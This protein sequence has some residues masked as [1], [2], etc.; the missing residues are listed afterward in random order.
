LSAHRD[1]PYIPE[2]RPPP[3]H[4]HREDPQ[5]SQTHEYSHTRDS[6]SVYCGAFVTTD[7]IE[8]MVRKR[9]EDQMGKYDKFPHPRR[10]RPASGPLSLKMYKL[11]PH[12]FKI[13]PSL[14]TFKGIDDQKDP[15]SF[16]HGFHD[17]LSLLGAF[18]GIICRVF[19]T[20]LIGEACDWYK[21]FPSGSIKSFDEFTDMF[22]KRYIHIKIP[23]V[24]VDSLLDMK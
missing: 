2:T 7:Q 19:S 3:S 17:L 23:R 24:T 22:L 5:L 16:I 20:C 10:F 13:L 15:E 9:V 11:T 1:E 8:E 6:S 12:D 14:D 4:I 21:N 18:D